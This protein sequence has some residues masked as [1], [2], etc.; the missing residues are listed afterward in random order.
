MDLTTIRVAASWSIKGLQVTT[1]SNIVVIGVRCTAC[2][3]EA[4]EGL[5]RDL[6]ER[7]CTGYSGL[8][9]THATGYYNQLH[10]LLVDTQQKVGYEGAYRKRAGENGYHLFIDEENS[11]EEPGNRPDSQNDDGDDINVVVIPSL[12]LSPNAP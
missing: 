10:T 5:L 2:R 12:N 9:R 7:G 8:R 6:V 1:R 11:D 3:L 4:L